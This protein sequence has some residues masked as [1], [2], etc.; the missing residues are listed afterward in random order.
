[1]SLAESFLTTAKDILMMSEN[2]KR[3]DSRIDRIADDLAGVDRRVMRMELLIELTKQ[4]S[5]RKSSAK[6]LP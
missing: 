4:H 2:I 6:E 1:M 5:P 3:M